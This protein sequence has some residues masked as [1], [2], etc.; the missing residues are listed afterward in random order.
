MTVTALMPGPTA[1]NFFR[2]AGMQDTRVGRG[3]KDSA[4]DVAHEG[5]E[6]MFSGRSKV[7]AGSFKN[8]LQVLVSRLLPDS[9][10]ARLHRRMLEQQPQQH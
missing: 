4:A 6:A 2:R 9:V 7:V 5:V 3:K 8:E 1:T 10:K